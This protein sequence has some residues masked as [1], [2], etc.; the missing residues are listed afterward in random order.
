MSAP[1]MLVLGGTAWLGRLVAA[2]GSEHGFE[3]TCLAR[4]IA[5][6]VPEGV[7]LVAADRSAADAYAGVSGQEWDA[8]VEVSWQTGF[9]ADA[10]AALS[11]TADRWPMCPRRRC[12]HATTSGDRT[13]PLPGVSRSPRARPS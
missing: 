4:G 10:L 9:V 3:V 12:T 2:R 11:A 6:D 7:R 1:R 5:G 8:V 13:R